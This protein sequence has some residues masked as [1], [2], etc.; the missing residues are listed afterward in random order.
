MHGDEQRAAAI[1]TTATTW[2]VCGRLKPNGN[3]KSKSSSK[4]LGASYHVKV[5]NFHLLL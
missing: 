3:E 5:T 2:M 4:V 1:H